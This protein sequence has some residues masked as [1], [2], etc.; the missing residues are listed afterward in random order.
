MNRV[1]TLFLSGIWLSGML[2]LA[3]LSSQPR[4]YADD[5]AGA[6]N[7]LSRAEAN[8]KSKDF[9]KAVY[10]LNEVIGASPT[11]TKGYLLRGKALFHT[12]KLNLAIE[13]FDRVLQYAPNTFSAFLWR[14]SAKSKL[15]DNDGAQ[16][17]YEQAIALNPRLAKRY[18]SKPTQAS[19]EAVA[20]MERFHLPG[21]SGED[22]KSPAI[23]AYRA[24][25]A[26]VFPKG[27]DSSNG[28]QLASSSTSDSEDDAY[29]SE[30]K[31]LQVR[32]SKG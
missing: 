13:D 24:A 29:L 4:A 17:D 32:K 15:G 16:K 7:A 27:F 19:S 6:N 20:N 5:Y 10:D 26:V 14:G 18:F 31:E 2:L 12:G 11:D 8:Y 25:M 21:V 9:D 22:L 23:K 1:G 30:I 28:V 3:A